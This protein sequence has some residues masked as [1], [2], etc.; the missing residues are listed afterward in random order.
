VAVP[1]GWWSDQHG[2]RGTANALTNDTLTDWGGGVA[3]GSTRV[4]V[5]AVYARQ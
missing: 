5:E 4:E 2:E 3:Y 1:F